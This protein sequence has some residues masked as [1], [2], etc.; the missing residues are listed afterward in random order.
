MLVREVFAWLRF[1]LN[2]DPVCC[3]QKIVV[4]EVPSVFTNVMDTNDG[5]RT[6]S[7]YSTQAGWSPRIEIRF[8]AAGPQVW[9]IDS[10]E[11]QLYMGSPWSSKFPGDFR[12]WNRAEFVAWLVDLAKAKLCK[13]VH[14]LITITAPEK[15]T[16]AAKLNLDVVERIINTVRNKI[17]ENKKTDNEKFNSWLK[18]NYQA[19]LKD[20]A[21]S[22]LYYLKTSKIKWEDIDILEDTY[23]PGKDIIPWSYLKRQILNDEKLMDKFP[24]NWIDRVHDDK[25][26]TSSY[27]EGV[28]KNI[29]EA[30]KGGNAVTAAV[31]EEFDL[32]CEIG[33]RC[34]EALASGKLPLPYL[35]LLEKCDIKEEIAP[36]SYIR[37]SVLAYEC[38]DKSDLPATLVQWLEESNLYPAL[39]QVEGSKTLEDLVKKR[40]ASYSEMTIRNANWVT[41]VLDSVVGKPEQDKGKILQTEF[42]MWLVQALSPSVSGSKIPFSPYAYNIGKKEQDLF[43]D[44]YGAWVGE[45]KDTVKSR[46]EASIRILGESLYHFY[47]QLSEKWENSCLRDVHYKPKIPSFKDITIL[48]QA[49][50]K[51][52]LLAT[53]VQDAECEV[54]AKMPAELTIEMLKCPYFNSLYKEIRFQSVHL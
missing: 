47:E 25:K 44:V 33:M 43:K 41:A 21:D 50:D 32:P 48:A 23:P 4:E 3:G 6:L 5:P 34:E 29:V 20:F 51:E 30:R 26:V 18:K 17:K 28:V 49:G 27:L 14:A 10:D 52:K 7:V 54:G 2:R 39:Y 11:K 36:W 42:D 38:S 31:A 45:L 53:L 22:A 46:K 12:M 40:L 35:D 9:F 8:A 19:D 37:R 15:T 16:A 24:P 13:D 1:S